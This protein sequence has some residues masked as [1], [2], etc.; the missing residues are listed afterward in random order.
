MLH[1]NAIAHRQLEM[2]CVFLKIVG[3]LVLGRKAVS[4]YRETQAGKDV[5]CRRE[6][7][8]R[9]PT[10]AP[11]VPHALVCVYDEERQALLLKVVAHAE[12]SLTPSDHQCLNPCCIPST[13]ICAP[14]EAPSIRVQ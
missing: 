4:P 5:A 9:V 13:H 12:A 8:Q 11:C 6:Q 7:A 1:S 14:P 10:V 3:Y 2:A